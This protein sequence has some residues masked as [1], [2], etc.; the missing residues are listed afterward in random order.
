MY[1]SLLPSLSLVSALSVFG[2]SLRL[3]LEIKPQSMFVFAWL[4]DVV[5]SFF[6]WDPSVKS[7]SHVYTCV[8]VLVFDICMSSYDK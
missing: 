5:S 2:L 8:Y 6:G 1:E 7:D 4:A 3:A